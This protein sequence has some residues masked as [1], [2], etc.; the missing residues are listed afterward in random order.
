MTALGIK[1]ASKEFSYNVQQVSEDELLK[2]KDSNFINAL[3][4]K[5]AGVTINRSAS[6]VGGSTRVVM[7]GTKSLAGDNNVLYVIEGIPL[8]NPT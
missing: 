8:S 6:G 3:S 4:G 2:N 7:R 5:V 1:R